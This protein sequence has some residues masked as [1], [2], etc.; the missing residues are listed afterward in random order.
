MRYKNNNKRLL[1]PDAVYNSRLVTRLINRVMKDGK[2]SVAINQVYKAFD[3]IGKKTKKEPLEV[4]KVALENIKPAM[5]VR[6][7]R[8]GGA[9]YQ[10]PAPVRG[11]RRESLAIRWIITTSRAK[12]NKDFH[13]FYEKLAA[14]I[15]DASQNQGEAIKKKENMHKMADANKA[16][17]HFRW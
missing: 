14:E 12:P 15:I 10:V 3:L 9:A 11:D 8:V 2:K 1:T 17:A 13:N 4:F 5:E 7:R 16:F 6:S